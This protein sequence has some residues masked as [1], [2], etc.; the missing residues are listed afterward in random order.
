MKKRLAALFLM[1]VM[2]LSCS[3]AWA[4]ESDDM[5]Y[6]TAQGVASINFTEEGLASYDIHRACLAALLIIEYQAN[7]EPDLEIDYTRDIYI[8]N[9]SDADAADDAQV[10][11]VVFTKTDGQHVT[12]YCENANVSCTCDQFA[13][14]VYDSDAAIEA[15]LKEMDAKWFDLITYDEIGEAYKTL[16]DIYNEALG[17]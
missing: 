1:V 6:F 10:Y 9:I 16:L 15:D 4:E 17:E 14:A 11:M 12:L 7:I 3:A 8:L 2:L 5:Q 13:D